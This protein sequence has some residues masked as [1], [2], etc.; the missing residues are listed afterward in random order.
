MQFVRRIAQAPSPQSNAISPLAYY[1]SVTRRTLIVAVSGLFFLSGA[2]GLIFETAWTRL[3]LGLFGH[4]IHTTSAVLAAFM[5][6][7]GLGALAAGRKAGRVRRPLRVYALLELAVA[8]WVVTSPFQVRLADLMVAG[9][10]AHSESLLVSDTVAWVVAFGLLMVPA[11]L[12]G[13]T[14]PVLCRA[15]ISEEAAIGRVFGLLYGINTIGAVIG[16]MGAGYWSILY[17]GVRGSLWLGCGLNLVAAAGALWLD[18]RQAPL[19]PR[20]DEA[21]SEQQRTGEGRDFRVIQVIV[22]IAGACA[23]AYEVVW[24]RLFV[25]ILG[26]SILSLAQVLG[27][28]LLALGLGAMILP[29][30]IR[31]RGRHLEALGWSQA[32]LALAAVGGVVAL[33]RLDELMALVAS[34]GGF[35]DPLSSLWGRA[36]VVAVIVFVPGLAMGATLPAATGAISDLR[37]AERGIG[38]RYAATTVGN[39][40]GALI[41]GYALVPSLAAARS[42]GVVAACNLLL[43]SAV[44][45]QFGGGRVVRRLATTA[46]ALVAAGVVLASIDA[47]AFRTVFAD[48]KA[49]GRLVEVSE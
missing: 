22:G 24:I 14:L 12:M 38:R 25:F 33:G 43:A 16:V 20:I 17:L 6:G 7:L 4:G 34:V 49:Y 5:G 26:S 44:A 41:A 32:L 9:M 2:S 47:D 19:K 23:M 27:T 18:R 29:R 3:F 35:S 46:A 11:A 36:L 28:L 42:L 45:W 21:P 1:P 15:L 13:A 10:A 8:A 39:I 30:L 48:R 31:S 37:D 40:V